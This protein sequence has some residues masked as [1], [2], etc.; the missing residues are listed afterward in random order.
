[1]ILEEIR[2][3]KSEKSDLRKFGITIG[4]ALGLLGGL[5][6]WKGKD[7][8]IIFEIIASIF[9]LL[10]LALPVL[11]KPLQ[12]AWMTLAVILGWFMTRVILSIL[13]YLV[14]SA[15][16]LGARLLGK[17]FLDLKMDDSK[18]SYWIKRPRK[19]FQRDDYERQ[20]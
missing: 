19:K 2:N 4:I 8:Y 18:N 15:I 9:I 16:G 13:F 6:W 12:K 10:G 5:L 17:G 1:M 14:F 3:I 7:T 20:Y 11:L